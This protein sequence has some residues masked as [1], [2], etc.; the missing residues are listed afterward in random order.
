MA[1]VGGLVEDDDGGD[2]GDQK[3]DVL[4]VDN[5]VTSLWK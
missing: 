1:A 3:G 4:V 2:G 5:W